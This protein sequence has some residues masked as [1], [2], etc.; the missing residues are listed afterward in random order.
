VSS[1]N[2]KGCEAMKHGPLIVILVL[3]FALT[4]IGSSGL[5]NEWFAEFEEI[6]SKVDKADS[7]STD[8]IKLLIERVDK[9]MPMVKNSD[10]PKRKVYLFRLKK[11]KGFFQYM[12]Q[13][14]E[15]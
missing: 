8:E 3:S 10:D 1:N 2:E 6:C 9:L 4:F 11:Y 5:C 7:L 12:I 15:S 14:R 13:L